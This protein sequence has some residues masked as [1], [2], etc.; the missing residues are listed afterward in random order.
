MEEGLEGSVMNNGGLDYDICGGGRVEKL[1]I[2]EHCEI[3][4][5]VD[6]RKVEFCLDQG[7]VAK[8]L[9]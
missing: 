1:R 3:S 2:R 5:L 6:I 8:V 7:A 4:L 9:R